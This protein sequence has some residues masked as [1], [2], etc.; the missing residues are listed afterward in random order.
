MIKDIVFE[1]IAREQKCPPEGLTL[2]TH[3]EDLGIDSLKAITILYQLEEQLEIEIPNELI[4]TIVT[5]GD[6]VTNIEQ[7]QQD[8]D[9]ECHDA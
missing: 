9:T 8:S 5:V 6:I 2:G 4:E 1:V 3:L 7:L